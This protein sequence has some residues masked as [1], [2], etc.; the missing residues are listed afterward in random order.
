MNHNEYNRYNIPTSALQIEVMG[1][2]SKRNRGNSKKQHSA[3][4]QQGGVTNT[5]A[6][7]DVVSA[8]AVVGNEIE[9]RSSSASIRIDPIDSLLVQLVE[10]EDLE[11][12]LK[13][14]SKFLL[15]AT[16][17]E[18][19]EPQKASY[20][21]LVIADALIATEFSS[22]KSRM[23]AIFLLERCFALSEIETFLNAC[24][25]ELVPLYLKEGRHDEAFAI[26][27]RI[28]VMIPHHE[29]IDPDLIL[30]LASEL[31]KASLNDKAIEIL[32]IFLGNINRS[33]D[34]D[35]RFLAYL[36]FGKGYTDLCE[37]EK[38][39]SF[40][41][42]ALAIT[43]DPGSKVTVLCDMGSMSRVACNYDDALAA[44]NQA[45]KILIAEPGERG[46]KS[47]SWWSNHTACVH[48]QIGD[49]L[50]D[51]GKRDLEALEKFDHALVIIKEEDPGNAVKLSG[52]YYAIGLVHARLGNW[53]EAIDY[54]KLAHRS[55]GKNTDGKNTDVKLTHFLAVLCKEIGRVRL[56]Q[57]FWDERLLRDTQE[58]ENVLREAGTFSQAAMKY[59]LYY[60]EYGLYI[61]TGILNCAQVAYFTTEIEEANKL[62][63]AY[64]ETEMK[65][66]LGIHCRSC[67]RK[68]VNGTDIKICRNCQVVDY[69]S[70]AHQTL[71]W[72]R[73]RLSHKVMCPFLKR[74]R[75][76]AKAENQH[77][78]TESYED[79]CKDFFETVCVLKYEVQY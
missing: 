59:G 66:K 74:Y 35:Q 21:Y 54:L 14:K 68:A 37:Y 78:D 39:D 12:I 19:T 53:D 73:G 67:N 6:T 60:E 15:R 52:I 20:T 63:M 16:A 45:L 55:A 40:L 43:D 50:S 27:K 33:W 34:K 69:C 36:T 58:R 13:Q 46:E 2:K 48:K 51:L 65:K 38:A 5:S 8:A 77:I 9:P 57:Y 22:K 62:L 10:K 72:R 24:V 32:T 49:V 42:K 4:A 31:Y 26:M 41:H 11:G 23:K 29:L 18:G 17:L 79:I 30:S 76:V 64:F 1:K 44:L 70:E 56:D 3:R 71:G 61:D 47:K 7:S 25:R 75:L 28:T